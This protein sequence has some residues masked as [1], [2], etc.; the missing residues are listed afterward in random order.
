VK[1]PV[2]LF[3]IK[4]P[5]LAYDISISDPAGMAALLQ[6]GVFGL[7]GYGTYEAMK[8]AAFYRGCALI[9]GTIASLPLRTYKNDPDRDG[10]EKIPSSSFLD[11]KPSGPYGLT[12]FAWKELI[13]FNVVSQGECGLLP[14]YTNG[15][16]LTGLW[17][18][19]RAQYTVKVIG[20]TR[21]YRVDMGHGHFEDHTD[22]DFVQ[23]VG[24]SLD[25]I[26]GISPIALFQRGIQLSAAQEIASM[27]Q[28][29]SGM[30]VAGLI[31]PASEDIS[32]EDAQAIQL[33]VNSKMLGPDKA[34]SMIM[35]N[36][37]LV[38]TKWDQTNDEAQFLELRRYAR[39][40]AALMLGLP[41]YMLEPSKQTS[42]GT[43]IAE[44][45]IGLQRFTFMPVTS[46]IE[47]AISAFINPSTKYVEWD[48]KGLLQG[49]PE[50]EVKLILQQLD[51]GIMSEEEARDL[52]GL[53]PKDPSD[54]FRE[55]VPASPAGKLPLEPP[56]AKP[57][58]APKD[59]S[60]ASN[61][62]M[63]AKM[64]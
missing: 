52:L 31:S 13:V 7:G 61:G 48:Y 8:F 21:H 57:P 19:S 6:S 29:T 49:T 37:R 24:L 62:K 45:N 46:R 23:I 60:G 47:E 14:V 40:E 35:T 2:R 56:E 41:I 64:V 36:K 58:M 32:P 43:G 55:P 10:D 33:D 38:F 51:A 28:A 30:K 9:A 3:G 15:G 34:G 5:Y 54:T 53:G 11:T 20:A 26:R 18:I 4:I 12:P 22:E 1:V 42:W 27:R 25:G 50:V 16:Q 59:E 44:Q 39:E 63:A 17:P